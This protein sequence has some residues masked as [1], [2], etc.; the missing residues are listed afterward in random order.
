MQNELDDFDI[1]WERRSQSLN[2]SHSPLS[3]EQWKEMVR[4]AQASSISV[5]HTHHHP[6]I[7]GIGSMAACVALAIGI[8]GHFSAA[9]QP[10]SVIYGN[11]SIR[12][13]CNNQCNAQS[14]IEYFD[15]YISKVEMI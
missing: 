3:P 10:T 14:T 13:I 5:K 9:A 4:N 15:S 2:C 7:W 11:Q 8:F 6:M 1:Q 12:F